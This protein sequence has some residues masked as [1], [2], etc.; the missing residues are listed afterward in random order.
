[1]MPSISLVVCT[2]G[3]TA[4]LERLFHSLRDQ[5]YD[6]GAYE[7]VLVDQNPEGTLRQIIAAFPDLPI[8]RVRSP[9][10]L[11]RA[12]NVGIGVARGGLVGFPDDDCWYPPATLAN[13]AGFFETSPDVAV[14]TGRT[15]DAEGRESLS[16]FQSESGFI[17]HVNAFQTGASPTLFARHSA[18]VAV[19]GFDETLGVGARTPFQSG[20]ETDFVLRV[21][22][23]G[24]FA[25]FDRSH[26][27]HHDQV[28]VDVG[29]ARGY[30]LGYGRVLRLH[31]YPS[32]DVFARAARTLAG[33]AVAAGRG[34]LADARVRL[35]W[36]AGTVAGYRAGE[37]A[38]PFRRIGLG[39]RDA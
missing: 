28:K 7:I 29:R 17:S 24:R 25:Y 35:A 36:F 2:I 22:A 4:P 15:L 26:V 1:M 3:R 30:A 32:R 13:V 20:E 37:T 16:R 31:G 14:L 33:S 10:G 34:Q 38:E 18:A 27:V 39:R 8:R 19:G 23:S 5:T 21:V 9:K 11:S 12:R 6:T